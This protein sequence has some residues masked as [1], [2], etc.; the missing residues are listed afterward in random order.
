MHA[1]FGN[2][3]RQNIFHELLA[4]AYFAMLD[5]GL[6]AKRNAARDWLCERERQLADEGML[7]ISRMPLSSFLSSLSANKDS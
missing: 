6:P 7:Q 5:L 1:D 3:D 4:A 2:A